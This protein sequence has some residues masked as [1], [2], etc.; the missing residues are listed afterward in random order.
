MAMTIK[1]VVKQEHHSLL[2][3]SAKGPNIYKIQQEP[4][5]LYR[6]DRP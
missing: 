5:W 1:K 2:L 4:Y 3:I 6:D